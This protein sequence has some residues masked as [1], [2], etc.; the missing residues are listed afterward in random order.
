V[1]GLSVEEG[2]IKK[3]LGKTGAF[4]NNEIISLLTSKK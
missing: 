1:A 2:V 4:A 3:G